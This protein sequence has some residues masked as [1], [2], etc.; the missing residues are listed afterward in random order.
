MMWHPCWRTVLCE[1]H[2]PAA[3]LS[4]KADEKRR[5]RERKY[6]GFVSFLY[7]AWGQ[8]VLFVKRREEMVF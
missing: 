8:Q 5:E 2:V 1:E 6:T 7:L 3:K 4:E